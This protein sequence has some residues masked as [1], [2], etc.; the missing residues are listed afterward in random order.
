MKKNRDAKEDLDLA[1]RIDYGVK[2]GV[3]EAVL[4]HKREGRSIF[5]EKNGKI[6]EIPPEEI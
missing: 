4:R 5:V 6:I 1:A 3:R 2:T